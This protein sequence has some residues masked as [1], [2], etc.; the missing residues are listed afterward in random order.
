MTSIFMVGTD[1][2]LMELK[3][4]DYDSEAL[5]QRLLADHPSVL[6]ISAGDELLLVGQEIP[7]PDEL[8]G[9]GRWAL[10]HLFLDRK[11]VPGLVEVKRASDTRA[12][13]EVVAQM[14]DYAANGVAYWPLEAIVDLF[15]RTSLRRGA[16]PDADLNAFLDNADADEFW[17]QV[18]ANLRSGRVRMVFVADRIP[19][20]LLRIIEFL[21]EQMRPAEVLAVEVEQFIASSG[22]RTLVPRRLGA[23]ERAL[24]A[25]AVGF[26]PPQLSLDQ[27]FDALM[28]ARGSEDVTTAKS[29]IRWLHDDGFDIGVSKSGD[30]VYAR[31]IRPDGKSSWPFF[32]RKSS[33]KFET[34]LGYLIHDRAYESDAARLDLLNRLRAL[35]DVTLSTSKINGWPGV[36]LADMRRDEVWLAVQAI[37]RE[38]RSKVVTGAKA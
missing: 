6:G 14:L 35:P 38:V 27:W 25:K 10:D 18:E 33:G 31:L 20:E 19:K 16:D 13:R 15:R 32:I 34:A 24:S 37:V 30:S 23:T 28:A 36:P 8:D 9:G 29:I 21:N 7:V 22:H 17:H 12:R 1:N 4:A 5:L 3:K 26:S 2:S 11:G